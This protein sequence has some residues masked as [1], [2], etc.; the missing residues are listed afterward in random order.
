MTEANL[1]ATIHSAMADIPA[2]E[3]DS[4]LAPGQ[5]H[6]KHSFLNTAETSGSVSNETGW[7]PCHITLRQNERLVGA[8]PLYQKSLFW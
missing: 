3:W 2:D 6:L 5:P 8:M 7:Q 1:T 4:L